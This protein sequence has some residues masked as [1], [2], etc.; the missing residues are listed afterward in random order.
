[1]RV[2]YWTTACLDPRIEAVSKELEDLRTRFGAGRTVALSEHLTRSICWS[3]AGMGLHPRFQNALR[4]LLPLLELF[5]DLNH[6]YAEVAPSTFLK[7]LRS[8]P[9]ILT[10]ASEK[11]DPRE[12]LVRRCSAIVVQTRGMA[13]RLVEAGVDAARIRLIYPGIDLGRFAPRSGAEVAP[14]RRV[15]FA[16]FPRAQDEIR[17]RGVAFLLEVA[18][19]HPDIEFDLVSRPWRSGGTALAAVKDELARRP[20]ANVVLHEGVHADMSGFYHRNA[21]TVIPYMSAAGGKECPRSLLESLACGVPA[22]VSRCAP[23]AEFVAEEGCGVVFEPSPS[24]FRAALEQGLADYPALS[25]RA[26]ASA[27]RHFDLE[28]TLLAYTALY[29]E[30]L[31][32]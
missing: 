24:G 25:A 14:S 22:L 3:R 29:A 20:R 17:D 2:S 4:A 28:Q 30:V 13:R 6:V 1:M 19:E 32:A 5:G 18:A 21:F 8:R 26:A 16:T 12:D 10:I 9:T 15:L 31:A 7:G 27:R 11:G 23:F